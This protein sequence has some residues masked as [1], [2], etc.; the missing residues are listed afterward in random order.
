MS[1]EVREGRKM[2]PRVFHGG[3]TAV[4]GASGRSC[5]M[6][7]GMEIR[8][9][10]VGDLS[11]VA[12]VGRLTVNDHPG[13]LKEAVA[14]VVADGS[15]HVLLDLSAVNY[16]DSTRLGELI[17]A[18]VTVARHGGKLRLVGTPERVLELLRM[19]GLD[20]IFEQFSNVEEARISISNA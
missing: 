11:V 10:R 2:L 15:R 1:R 19:A 8:E 9:T 17:A 14:R 18:H 5:T 3:N 13:L 12:L 16:I 6:T 7:A 4:A 20:G